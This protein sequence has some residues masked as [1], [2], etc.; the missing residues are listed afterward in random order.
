MIRLHPMDIV[1]A[2]LAVII[3]LT[4]C[5][6]P[7][8]AL[9][10][11]SAGGYTPNPFV[12]TVPVNKSTGITVDY[13][14]F[15]IPDALSIEYNGERI[16]GT[17]GQVAG[18][19]TVAA[20]VPYTTGVN[21]AFVKIYPNTNQQTQWTMRIRDTRLPSDGPPKSGQPPCDT[22]LAT[23]SQGKSFV[24]DIQLD[25]FHEATDFATAIPEGCT[26]C[27]GAAPTF[28]D[29]PRLELRRVHRYRHFDRQGSFGPGVF[30]N[31]DVRLQIAM[32][33]TWAELFDPFNYQAIRATFKRDAPGAFT[34]KFTEDET[35]LLRQILLKDATGDPTDTVRNGGRAE[36][37]YWDG[38]SDVFE[39]F[40]ESDRSNGVT[41]T[42][43]FG[44]L[45]ARRDANGNALTITYVHAIP[46][47]GVAAGSDG[48]GAWEM[49]QV[50]DAFGATLRFAYAR[51]LTGRTITQ[52]DQPGGGSIRY[53]YDQNRMV[54]LSGI[55]YPTGERS[56]FSSEPDEQNFLQKVTIDDAGAAGTHRRKILGLTTTGWG[57][58][59]AGYH[60]SSTALNMP[61]NRCVQI[62]DTEQVSVYEV[63]VRSLGT[64]KT[65]PAVAGHETALPEVTYNY[66]IFVQEPGDSTDDGVRLKRIDSRDGKT[67]AMWRCKG[68]KGGD[69]LQVV[70]DLPWVLMER[71]DTNGKNRV[72][73]KSQ[74]DH[75][76]T[77]LER[78]EAGNPTRT[79][80]YAATGTTGT[81]IESETSYNLIQ[82]PVR[83]V[84]RAGRVT[85]RTYWPTQDGPNVERLTEGVGT[86]A[87][88]STRWT[89]NGRGQ[90]LTMTDPDGF[91]TTYTY[92][93]NNRMASVTK[94]EIAGQPRARWLFGYDAAGRLTTVT[95]PESRVTTFGY[96]TRNRLVSTT[97]ADQTVETRSYGSGMTANL[98]V[99]TV[100]RNGNVRRFSYDAVGRV[101]GE[102]L[103]PPNPTAQTPAVT[104][105]ERTYVPGTEWVLTQRENG[106]W[107]E[108]RYDHL[109]RMTSSTQL[110]A[111]DKTLTT[112]YSYDLRDRLIRVFDP[113]GRRTAYTRDHNNLVT[114]E[115]R[116][117][118][119]AVPR[120]G[121]SGSFTGTP[122]LTTGLYIGPAV[123]RP[124][125]EVPK[126]QLVTIQGYDHEGNLYYRRDPRGIVTEYRLD[127]LGR[128]DM[129]VTGYTD[130]ASI[131]NASGLMGD[132]LR[133]S[134]DYNKRGL[135]EVE[136]RRFV[137]R[138][139]V[140]GGPT[141]LPFTTHMDY[142]PTT[143]RRRYDARGQLISETVAEGTSDAATVVSSYTATGKLATR[144]DPRNPAWLTTMVYGGCC[145]RLSR[146]FDAL[147]F[148]TDF[149]YDNNGNR[150][151]VTN[152]LTVVTRTTYDAANRIRTQTDGTGATSETQYDDDLGD[153]VGLDAL[154]KP[155]LERV[156][157]GF[158]RQSGINDAPPNRW[159]GL[160]G[161]SPAQP[162]LSA[163]I[164]K[165]LPKR[166]GF[167]A[168][169]TWNALR[170]RS[171][172]IADPL[173]RT[174]A[175]VDPD[176]TMTWTNYDTLEA[177]TNL[178]ATTVRDASGGIVI[179][180]AD[181][182]GRVRKV[183][184]QRHPV[185]KPDAV[186]LTTHDANGNVVRVVDP[187]GGTT[188]M[189]YDNFNRLC[190]TIDPSGLTTRR[191]YDP[192]GNL[193]VQAGPEAQVT[194]GPVAQ[195]AYQQAL[196]ITAVSGADVFTYDRRDRQV[197]ATDRL[198]YQT[199]FGYDAAGNRTR[200]T[201]AQGG[202]TQYTFTARNALETETFP[203]S[204]GGT[205]TRTYD[206][207]GRLE[208]L[209][210]QRGI[211]TTFGYDRADRLT[212][213][214]YSDGSRDDLELDALGRPTKATA[215]RSG[216]VIDRV[217]T[218]RG[219]LDRETTTWP[220]G[221]DGLPV[222][223]VVRHAYDAQGRR[224]ALTYPDSRVLVSG[225][226]P[227]GET[228]TLTWSGQRIATM[229]YDL[230]G[231]KTRSDLGNGL[232]EER[233]WTPDNRV[234]SI[235]VSS[236]LGS[237]IIDQFVSYDSLRRVQSDA[238]R[239]DTAQTQVF[240]YDRADRLIAFTVGAMPTDTWTLTAVGDW[241][242]AT[243]GGINETRAHTAVHE[244][245]RVNGT[246]L[247]NDAAGNMTRDQAGRV[248]VWDPENKLA[249]A[250][251]RDDAEGVGYRIRHSYDAFGRRVATVAANTRTLYV[252]DD[253]RV[254]D[255]IDMPVVLPP[256]A[257]EDDGGLDRLAVVPDGAIMFPTFDEDG[258]QHNPIRVN[259]QP[260][261]IEMPD[262][263][264][265]DKGKALA[266]RTSG[267]SY[268]W[269]DGSGPAARASAVAR[270]F[271]P[272]PQYDTLIGAGE[273]G[274]GWRWSIALPNGTYP[275]AI[276]A[277]DATSLAHTNNLVVNGQPLPVDP[278]P[279]NADTVP[280]YEYGDFDGWVVQV[281]VTDGE[282][283][284]EAGSGA[285]DP[286]LC[287][288]EIAPEGALTAEELADL[289]ARLDDEVA[290][291]TARTGGSASELAGKTER[292]VIVHGAAYLDEVV[293]FERDGQR[294]YLHP[295]RNWSPLAATTNS[296]Q[297]VERYTFDAYGRRNVVS[298][299]RPAGDRSWIGNAVGFTGYRFDPAMGLYY[300]RNRMY[301]AFLGR[302]VSRDPSGYIDGWSLYRAYF[303]PNGMDPFG[304][305]EEEGGFFSRLW[306]SAR[307]I[308]NA[309]GA[310]IGVAD[311]NHELQNQYNPL[312]RAKRQGGAIQTATEISF[313]VAVG[314]TAIAGGAIVIEG[315]A[316]VAKST[317]EVSKIVWADAQ[318]A[319]TAG[320]SGG[321]LTVAAA[322]PTGQAVIRG[323][324]DTV[325]MY[326]TGGIRPQIGGGLV[327]FTDDVGAAGIRQSEQLIGKTGIFALPAQYAD[328]GVGAVVAR[329]GL[330]PGKATNYVELPSAAESLFTRPTPIG[331]YSAWKYFG[332]V[333]Y[334]PP[335][336][337]DM[338]TGAFTPMRSLIG[339]RTLIYGPDAL[340]YAGAG[341][342]A[343]WAYSMLGG[344]ELNHQ[345]KTPCE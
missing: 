262:G 234:E 238:D 292:R 139:A 84:D 41:I 248:F 137:R 115:H 322:S 329:T 96:D 5:A 57:Y 287:F 303:C 182:A 283:V 307:A 288:V 310:G 240:G 43:P 345:T 299:G 11:H 1:A 62:W 97:Y 65:L 323:L 18:H 55:Q 210:D 86:P 127:G 14:M 265:A 221:A 327:H 272:M 243:R 196:A 180:Y 60:S 223:R 300:A 215:G 317:V 85:E 341:A 136:S 260:A 164:A 325:A 141:T 169:V 344:A 50:T 326:S 232:V 268:G 253:W 274:Q 118:L 293:C 199:T 68:W 63:W 108:M 264:L 59:Q 203:G 27:G 147:G 246:A 340:F 339:P 306:G 143:T 22:N 269:S 83:S 276:V 52:V 256:A 42:R 333:Q 113:F 54:G 285:F 218:N 28:G 216:V 156:P 102:R 48:G 116:D 227:R 74:A 228:E 155:F 318:L 72:E 34:G 158:P 332:G 319:A 251:V 87:E 148:P 336:T 162:V 296:G 184:D 90:P 40:L 70:D 191:Y 250:Q 153:G 3:A 78:N 36:V 335:G 21:Q 334:A 207:L 324:Q 219:H 314:A 275:V 179:S 119:A 305:D 17:P 134:Y 277:G 100:D 61:S 80:L 91:V 129:V 185:G 29:M 15:T 181:A 168:T 233:T 51:S 161:A 163:P 98:L 224:T 273:A 150:T 242:R 213:R 316:V 257:A 4:A 120:T 266:E 247:A 109:G 149:G 92:D 208:T 214:S 144:S 33:G 38:R 282:L 295:N 159:Q 297:V 291:A 13:E 140:P 8:A 261:Q 189:G 298:S 205:R 226:T 235:L 138:N 93:A 45:V 176:D 172:T 222:S 114:L 284:I 25:H 237:R 69:L 281:E 103:F 95:D 44:R 64:N 77:T 204:T 133:V 73:N 171:I 309:A 308:G 49:S 6:A 19:S 101:I 289:T 66:Q 195:T 152:A 106:A 321:G 290:K 192:A 209:T 278:D 79:T 117:L 200:I 206:A 99:Q 241:Q 123:V 252:H 343:G 255:E 39:T 23:I 267:L 104:V 245:T 12:V 271:H 37:H 175:T 56:T 186:T 46:G 193:L 121:G 132:F 244:V 230:G 128:P 330:T 76:V 304:L 126:E 16:G 35:A 194:W 338:A 107:S 2:R 94:P 30:S 112:T 177:S 20:E 337:I 154:V 259:F 167:K 165:R 202:V 170:Q 71:F 122:R 31:Y 198:G 201:D 183:V 313:G 229:T 301:S 135:V 89:Y 311:Y 166:A 212:S 342:F 105:S 328:E 124:A 225:Y 178:V 315:G 331:P 211:V 286:T 125:S 32:G 75:G 81:V 258:T 254:I 249:V 7:L 142:L 131:P 58:G 190:I 53:T 188:V 280:A 151:T 145:D 220:A 160:L 67:V 47:T 26:S 187:N 231:R 270:R 82:R 312:L 130:P 320:V 279:G 111:A 146:T 302:F 110:V 157:A 88:R 263:F 217:Y 239:R 173:G 174:V 294:Y 9:E 10:Q 24:D 197:S 236:V